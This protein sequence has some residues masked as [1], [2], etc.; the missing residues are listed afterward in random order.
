MFSVFHSASRK[1]TTRPQLTCIDVKRET[2]RVVVMSLLSCLV[3]PLVSF[4][5]GYFPRLLLQGVEGGSPIV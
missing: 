2:F 4:N 5:I 3:V 1:N